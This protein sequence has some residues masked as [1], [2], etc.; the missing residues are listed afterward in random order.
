MQVVVKALKLIEIAVSKYM[1][2]NMVLLVDINKDSA[3]GMIGTLLYGKLHDPT[4]EVRDSALEVL[5]TI[6]ENAVSSKRL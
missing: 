5:R 6:S 2:P 3:I 4:W 1:T